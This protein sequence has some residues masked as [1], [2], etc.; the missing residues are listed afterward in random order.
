MI[1]ELSEIREEINSLKKRIELLEDKKI[2]SDSDKDIDTDIL[3][4]ILDESIKAGTIKEDNFEYLLDKK[5]LYNIAKR[6]GIRKQ[7]LNRN[8]FK[9][10]AIVRNHNTIYIQRRINN[11][12]TWLFVINKEKWI[13]ELKKVNYGR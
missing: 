11:K 7:Y 6:Y 10:K 13:E 4:K 12:P 2:V 9:V 8:L 3:I 1:N 5:I